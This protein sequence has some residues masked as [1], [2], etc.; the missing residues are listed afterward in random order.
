MKSLV[1]T[2]ENEKEL[3]FIKKLI[4]KLGYPVRELTEEE[5][6]DMGLLRAMVSERKEDYVSEKEIRKALRKK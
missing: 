6:E 1:I 3:S 2:P 5:T 4:E